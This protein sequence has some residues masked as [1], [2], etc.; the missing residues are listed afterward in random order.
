MPRSKYWLSSLIESWVRTSPQLWKTMS[1]TCAM[2]HC[3]M[4]MAKL[5]NCCYH[6]NAYHQACTCTMSYIW[7]WIHVSLKFYTMSCMPSPLLGKD[8]MAPM[9]WVVYSYLTALPKSMSGNNKFYF[10]STNIFL[11]CN[12]LLSC[13]I[14]LL[15]RWSYNIIANKWD[16]CLWY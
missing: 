11:P 1:I 5:H 6:S 7:I 14:L 2:W 9:S 10:I 8:D 16:I 3:C 15:P 12:R 13:L 4:S